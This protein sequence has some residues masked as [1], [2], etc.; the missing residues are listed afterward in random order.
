MDP[1]QRTR[2]FDE[3]GIIEFMVSI[4]ATGSD[5]P[6]FATIGGATLKY[7]L[8]SQKI[9]ADPNAYPAFQFKANID[10]FDDAA[11]HTQLETASQLFSKL[12]YSS[13]KPMFHMVPTMGADNNLGPEEFTTAARLISIVNN[14]G[15]TL[16]PFSLDFDHFTY[17]FEV[18]GHQTDPAKCLVTIYVKSK[19]NPSL[20]LSKEITVAVQKSTETVLDAK[21]KNFL[22]SGGGQRVNVQQKDT[23]TDADVRAYFPSLSSEFS[24]TDYQFSA[25]VIDIGV[26]QDF[27]IFAEYKGSDIGRN[28]MLEKAVRVTA[29]SPAPTPDMEAQSIYI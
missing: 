7:D 1:A 24:A 23:Y 18:K 21:I 5:T 10:G 9:S 22:S 15:F 25:K 17:A 19:T 12:V 2:I 8:S 26:G 3:L 27:V 16:N 14:N 28:F 13:D 11:T 6:S 20:S 29:A 4:S